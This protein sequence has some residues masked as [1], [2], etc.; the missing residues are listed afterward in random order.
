MKV[1]VGIVLAL[2]IFGYGDAKQ[3][4]ASCLFCTEDGECRSCYKSG[5]QEGKC[6]GSIADIPE[7]CWA[8]GAA[9]CD[10]C[11]PGYYLSSDGKCLVQE[12][13]G[14]ER[15]PNKPLAL[16]KGTASN[17]NP[18]PC[19]LGFYHPGIKKVACGICLYSYSNAENW[20][21]SIPLVSEGLDSK[22]YPNSKCVQGGIKSPET[23]YQDLSGQQQYLEA[24]C[25]Y[26][27]DDYVSVEG[28]CQHKTS[29]YKNFDSTIDQL[30]P[31]CAMIKN[32]KCHS[33]RWSEGFFMTETGV[34][35]PNERWEGNED[36]ELLGLGIEVQS[37]VQNSEESLEVVEDL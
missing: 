24:I 8:G 27:Q 11:F 15:E 2:L 14:I 21:C 35:T 37:V 18:Y 34:C 30:F 23:D 9:G 12:Q 4:S 32:T 28:E 31:G 16:P 22:K 6:V 36:R 19:F 3:C 25:F 20:T 7:N 13:N 33:C 29:Q 26:C 1:G 5:F 10:Q 17:N